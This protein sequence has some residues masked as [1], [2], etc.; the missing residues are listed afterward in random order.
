MA[1][2]SENQ[3]ELKEEIM[4]ALRSVVKKHAQHH[5]QGDKYKVTLRE[6]GSELMELQS[7][8]LEF[9]VIE[10]RIH[11]N[12]PENLIRIARKQHAKQ[13]REGEQFEISIIKDQGLSREIGGGNKPDYNERQAQAQEEGLAEEEKEEEIMMGCNCGWQASMTEVLDKEGGYVEEQ[14]PKKSKYDAAKKQKKS[15]YGGTAGPKNS[16]STYKG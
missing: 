15:E 14:D 6:K 16:N 10:K 5:G 4:R 1:S 7:S 8:E 2:M 12:L 11:E 9:K 3:E 13:H